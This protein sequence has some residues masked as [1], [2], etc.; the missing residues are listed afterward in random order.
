LK[1]SLNKIT[2]RYNKLKQKTEKICM[3][4]N[5]TDD[6]EE[7]KGW[8]VVIADMQ[9][10]MESRISELTQKVG[11]TNMVCTLALGEQ[12]SQDKWVCKWNYLYF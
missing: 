8:N 12:E 11:Q 9:K 3:T 2:T 4:A 1:E 5:I 6:L 7:A 10:K